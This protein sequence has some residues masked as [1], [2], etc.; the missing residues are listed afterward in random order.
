MSTSIDTTPI[1]GLDALL[2]GGRVEPTVV[3][4]ATVVEDGVVVGDG[5]VEG[6]VVVGGVVGTSVAWG[7]VF[8][9]W[10]AVVS[11]WVLGCNTVVLVLES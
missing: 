6:G 4:V 3:W 10:V 1:V 9:G 2:V 11:G 7:S 5:M 8:R